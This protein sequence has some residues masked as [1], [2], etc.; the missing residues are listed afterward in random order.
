MRT[1][2]GVGLALALIAGC[3]QSDKAEGGGGPKASGS[4]QLDPAAKQLEAAGKKL[5]DDRPALSAEQ[6]EQLLLSLAKCSLKYNAIDYGC[7]EKRAWDE[8]RTRSNAL[9]DWAGMSAAL[10]K[11]HIKHESAAVRIQAASLLGSILG[12]DKSSQT[13]LLEAARAEKEPAVLSAILDTL[14]NE[15]KR[16][17]DVGKLLL[18]MADHPLAA[19]RTKAVLCLCSGWNR[20]MDGAVDKL[21]EK[22]DKD[23][24]PEVRA[25]ACTFSGSHG[26]DRLVAVYDR[27]TK[28]PTKDPKL[29]A[30]CLEGLVHSWANYPLYETTNEKAYRLTLQRLGQTPRSAQVP[31]WTL[32]GE[33]KHLAKS[34]HK[35]LQEWKGKASWFKPADLL[36]PL[37]GIITDP[38]ARSVART[39]ALESVVALGADKAALQRMRKT[40]DGSREFD[41]QSVI[42]ALDKAIAAAK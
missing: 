39:N 38:K 6:Y 32:M 19:V 41:D 35:S 16:N 28:D 10:G 17:P 34:D 3:A 42:E 18:E 8:G 9:E 30:G 31:P 25:V 40:Y 11:K 24:A 15:G 33:F 12:T 22:I 7:P 20:G 23:A 13:V 4:S 36:K 5:T 2:I 14:A 37:E 26:D 21:I 1:F 27:L 29:Y